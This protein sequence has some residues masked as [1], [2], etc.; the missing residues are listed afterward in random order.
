M[1]IRRHAL[2]RHE[3][4]FKECG[5]RYR[6]RQKDKQRKWQKEE[7][8][9]EK[10]SESPCRTQ[11]VFFCC[12]ANESRCINLKCCFWTFF[13]LVVS[14]YD[15]WYF[16][17]SNFHVWRNVNYFANLNYGFISTSLPKSQRDQ[18][19]WAW[20]QPWGRSIVKSLLMACDLGILW[21]WVQVFHQLLL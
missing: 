15:L 7:E 21:K 14:V 10:A 12:H 8:E 19:Q 11:N 6:E 4:L 5:Q 17:E 20:W 16:G 3:M 9:A 1:R 18:E 2:L 13:H